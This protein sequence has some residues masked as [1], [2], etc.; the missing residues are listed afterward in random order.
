MRRHW[1]KVL[2]VTVIWLAAGL[3][4]ALALGGAAGAKPTPC[5]QSYDGCPTTTVPVT[6]VPT[7]TVPGPPPCFDPYTPDVAG[8]PTIPPTTVP[9]Q[10][11]PPTV[12]DDG[13]PPVAADPA[14]TG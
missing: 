6:T 9:P 4:V 2:A 12:F 3:V 1:K 14:V 10:V 7:T 13:D 8:C 5:E 11:P